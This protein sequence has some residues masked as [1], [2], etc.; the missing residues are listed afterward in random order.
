MSRPFKPTLLLAILALPAAL[1]GQTIYQWTGLAATVVGSEAYASGSTPGNW[2]NDTPPAT[3]ATATNNILSFGPLSNAG[4]N[5]MSVIYS[6]SLNVLGVNFSSNRPDYFFSTSNA[7]GLGAGGINVDSGSNVYLGGDLKLFTPQTW[8]VASGTSLYLYGTVTDNSTPVA[9]TKTGDGNLILDNASSTFAGG[10]TISAGTL[11]VG[12]SS[13]SSNGSLLQG[14]VGTGTLT[15][16]DNTSLRTDTYSDVTLE[17]NIHLGSNVT[18]GNTAERNS[19]TLGGVITPLQTDTTVNVGVDGALFIPGTI[20]NVSSGTATNITFKKAAKDT[21]ATFT[22]NQV[23][24]SFPVAVLSGANS[25]TG[26]TTADGMGVIFFSPTAHDST[27]DIAAANRGYIGLGYSTSTGM[28]SIIAKISDKTKFDGSLGFDTHP[29]SDTINTFGGAIDLSGFLSDSSPSAGFWGL[30][31]QT[32]AVISSNAVI[33]PPTGGNYVF[34]GGE[35]TLYVEAALTTPAGATAPVGVRVRSDFDDR[36]LSVWLQPNADHANTFNGSLLSDHSIV[37]LNSAF[38]LPAAASFGMDSHGY[39]GY[40]EA[41]S[42][43][44]ATF[45][46]RVSGYEASSILGFDSNSSDGRDIADPVDLRNFTDIFI[47]TSTHVHLTS[48]DIKAPSSG[49]LAVTGV[50]GGLLNL[51]GKLSATNVGSLLVGNSGSY[52]SDSFDASYVAVTNGANDF[53]GGTT[54]DRGYLL[55]GASSTA[56]ASPGTVAQGPLGT[57]TLTINASSY[58]NSAAIIPTTNGLTLHNNIVFNTGSR[59]QFGASYAEDS[60]S[61][62]TR[63]ETY[64]NNGLTLAGQLS[65]NPSM[66]GL[67]SNG[68]INLTADNSNLTSFI[69]VGSESSRG[70]TTPLVVAQHNQALGSTNST[71]YLASGADLQFTTLAPTIGT[72]MGGNA[73]QNDGPSDLSYIGLLDGATLTINQHADGVLEASIGAMPANPSGLTAPTATTASLVK[74]GTGTLTLTGQNNYTGGTTI[75]GGKLIAGNAQALGSGAITVNGGQLGLADGASL[76]NDI[77]F[78]GTGNVL[79]GSG[80]FTSLINV[81]SALTLAPGNSPGQL[82]FAGGLTFSGGGTLSLDIAD[83][84]GTAGTDYDFVNVSGGSFAIAATSANPFTIRINSL[85]STNGAIGLLGNSSSS[86]ASLQILLSPNTIA[87]FDPAKFV[88]DTSNFSSS[89]PGNFSL[90][91]GGANN[92]ALMLNFTPVPEPSTYALL[93]LG[94]LVVGYAAHRRARRS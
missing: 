2:L 86:A 76:A 53:T 94:L 57:G 14:P 60:D 50:K 27:T 41:T 18:I 58:N 55:L 17:N 28:A 93:G 47:G 64:I 37:V 62:A 63:V 67:A 13:Y 91:V 88:L 74:N 54:L 42:F 3:D 69:M 89:T 36:P 83:L 43:T 77:T 66:I 49:V 1:F 61:S 21:F 51:D 59:V 79:G 15:L 70:Y 90:A 82:T 23:D 8:T 6:D 92:N 40:T 38:A 22:T 72:I 30:G 31:S 9:L 24:H 32:K 34:G 25:Y 5:S 33:T 75:S 52:Y 11:Y 71:L 48:N 56:G 80:T 81:N 29:D 46:T 26:R 45:M 35:G 78:T 39:V 20:T 12:G 73:A 68:T 87:D 7:V 65:G 44:P 19:L 16:A 85:T 84:Y 4:I 10:L